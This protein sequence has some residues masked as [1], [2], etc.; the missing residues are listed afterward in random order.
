MSVQRHVQRAKTEYL[1]SEDEV[2]ESAQEI[3]AVD[4]STAGIYF[5]SVTNREEIIQPGS[6]YGTGLYW[7]SETRCHPKKKKIA[8]GKKITIATSY[9]QVHSMQR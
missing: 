8:P 4:D 3:N 5:S 6:C 1:E 9:S 7:F 2:E